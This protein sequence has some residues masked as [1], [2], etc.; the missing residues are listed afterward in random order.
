MAMAGIVFSQLREVA[1]KANLT[2]T[3]RTATSKS[4]EGL[5]TERLKE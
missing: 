4:L 1:E 2:L 3:S 5:V